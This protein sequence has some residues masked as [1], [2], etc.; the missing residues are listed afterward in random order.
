MALIKR[1]TAKFWSSSS[2][3]T[4]ARAPAPLTHC[5]V[6]AELDCIGITG[7]RICDGCCASW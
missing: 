6:A 5:P 3:S 2:T 7:S 4:P 1:G